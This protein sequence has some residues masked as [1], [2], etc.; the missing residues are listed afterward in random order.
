MHTSKLAAL[1]LAFLSPLVGEYLLGNISI[2]D[3]VAVPFLVPMYGGGALLIREL[4]RRTGRGWPTIL[5]LGLAYGVIE[6]G[7]F[8]GSLFNP[9]F[10]GMDYAGARIPVLGLSAYYAVQF[11]VNHAVWSITIPILLTEALTPRHRTTPWL[12][13]VGLGVTA[14]VYVLGGLLIRSDSV[15]RGEYRTSWAQAAG[16]VL[17]ALVLVTVAFSLPRPSPGRSAGW[18]PRPWLVGVA[19]FLLSSGYFLLPASWRG[20]AASVKIIVGT[21][22]VVAWLSRRAGWHAGHR[23]ALAT[24]AL[25]TYAWAG[26]LLTAIKHHNDPVAFVGNGVLAVAAIV[27]VAVAAGRGGG[28]ENRSLVPRADG[29]R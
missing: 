25:M 20:V 11:L 21:A 12:G 3:L 24:G 13:R 22:L 16:V 14:V 1:G 2:R 29:C 23:I 18:V 5:V 10:E 19:A 8:D 28:A 27:L 6:P 17:V 15:D 4:A 9:S 26:F 7:V